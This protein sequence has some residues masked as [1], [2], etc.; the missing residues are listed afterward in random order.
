MANGNTLFDWQGDIDGLSVSDGAFVVVTADGS[1]HAKYNAVA[2]LLRRIRKVLGLDVVFVSLF[3]GGQPQVRYPDEDGGDDCDPLERAF[4][5][6]WLACDSADGAL[7]LP[8]AGR[9]GWI[10]GTLSCKVHADGGAWGDRSQVE[11]LESV[12]GLLATALDEALAPLTSDFGAL[13]PSIMPAEAQA[14][15]A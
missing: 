11:A 5:R 8:V 1:D 2:A 6:Q 13:M 3:I 9:E 7:A 15:P 4:A 14:L 10:Y 12:A